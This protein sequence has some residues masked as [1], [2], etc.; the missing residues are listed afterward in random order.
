MGDNK[1]LYVSLQFD[2]LVNLLGFSLPIPSCFTKDIPALYV[3]LLGLVPPL[4]V[5]LVTV[6][7]VLRYIAGIY[8][9]S[10]YHVIHCTVHDSFV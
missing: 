2:V 4:L 8:C 1:H 3:A 10:D 6:A 9:V 7:Y 5:T